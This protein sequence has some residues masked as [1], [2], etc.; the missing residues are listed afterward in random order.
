MLTFCRLVFT[1]VVTIWGGV[2]IAGYASR[3]FDDGARLLGG[4]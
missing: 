3:L 2:L 4:R 1:V